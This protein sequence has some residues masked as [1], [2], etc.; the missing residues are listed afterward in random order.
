MAKAKTLPS[1]LKETLLDAMS[2]AETSIEAAD[3]LV[4]QFKQLLTDAKM[5][6]KYGDIL[7]KVEDFAKYTKFKLLSNSQPWLGQSAAP[8][9]FK[10]MQANIAIDE[11][12]KLESLDVG[13]EKEITFD[14]AV[15]DQTSE[16]QRGC[17]VRQEALGS[18]DKL[19]NAWLAE[20]NL[21]STESTL[22]ETTEN[23][24][25]KQD[26]QGK[27]VK[28]NPEEVKKL[29]NDPEQGFAKYMEAKG[30]K[31]V[32]R[33]QEYPTVEKGAQAKQAVKEA[34]KAAPEAVASE[35]AVEPQ[36]TMRTG[37]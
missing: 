7:Q 37:G 6:D 25:I 20:K 28:A 1:N 15:H 4:T 33:E 24:Q 32:C 36:T 3:Y 14:F 21:R 5:L 19:F 29:I 31:V 26:A 2:V 18:F 10:N 16:F 35:E 12:K 22:Y 11:V 8:S 30:I 17:S 13:A 27:P 34:I 9:D 23:G